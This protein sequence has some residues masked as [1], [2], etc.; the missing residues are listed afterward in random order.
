M[1]LKDSLVRVVLQ[2]T[3]IQDGLTEFLVDKYIEVKSKTN[4]KRDLGTNVGVVEY[5]NS[6]WYKFYMKY[7]IKINTITAASFL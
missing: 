5:I 4:K 7:V 6:H 3:Y 2:V 1:N